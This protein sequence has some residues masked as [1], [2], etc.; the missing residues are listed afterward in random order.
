MDCVNGSNLQSS[1]RDLNEG[2]VRAI[3][4]WD[5][6]RSALQ[7]LQKGLGDRSTGTILVRWDDTRH[8]LYGIEWQ[9][10]YMPDTQAFREE[11]RFKL[12]EIT[13]SS[14]I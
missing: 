2:D 11:I 8:A 10:A 1:I 4:D 12:A 13:S 3:R 14:L 7:N 9:A 5:R 6:A